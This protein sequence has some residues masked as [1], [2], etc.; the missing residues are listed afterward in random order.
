[1]SEAL[2]VDLNGT[3]IRR[4]YETFAAIAKDVDPAIARAVAD[5]PRPYP[6]QH[7]QL[8][9]NDPTPSRLRHRASW[10]CAREILEC[11]SLHL[12]ASI[13]ASGFLEPAYPS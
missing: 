4:M 9:P 6:R 1:M 13:P 5:Q 11:V 10:F 7:Q 3:Q 8:P 12:S 2:R